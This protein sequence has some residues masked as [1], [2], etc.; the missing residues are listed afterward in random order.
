MVV[1]LGMLN[2]GEVVLNFVTGKETSKFL[3]DELGSIGSHHE[4]RHPEMGEDVPPNKL[5][6]LGR[7]FTYPEVSG[8]TSTHL[9]K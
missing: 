9:V 6:S 2:G 7:Y 8:S 3:V 5:L 4:V 1:G